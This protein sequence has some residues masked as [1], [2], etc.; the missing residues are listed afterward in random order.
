MVSVA[1][2]LSERTWVDKG[3]VCGEKDIGGQGYGMY[4]EGVCLCVGPDPWVVCRGGRIPR[5]C[6]LNLQGPVNRNL[7]SLLHRGRYMSN[8][9]ATSMISTISFAP[10][11]SFVVELAVPKAASALSGARGRLFR[12]L[13]GAHM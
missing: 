1:V 5:D 12:A 2:T 6:V 10:S 9:E 4:E 13:A 11:P 8:G 7:R 3:M